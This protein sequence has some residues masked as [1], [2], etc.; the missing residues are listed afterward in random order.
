MK[1]MV[2]VKG[3][4]GYWVTYVPESQVDD[5]RDDGVDVMAIQNIIPMWA[6]KWRVVPVL[7]F[8]QN[9]YDMPSRIW[10]WLR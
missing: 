6:I 10:R 5:M 8:L 1:Y 4:S 2:Q 3:R 9:L 7:L